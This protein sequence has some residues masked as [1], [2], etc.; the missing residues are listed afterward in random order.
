MKNDI[1]R[2]NNERAEKVKKIFTINNNNNNWMKNLLKKLICFV[3]IG[4]NEI[5][6]KKDT[7][8]YRSGNSNS[9]N[10]KR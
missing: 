9:K 2:R 3:S 10:P 6:P 4:R 1:P 8:E 5:I 7:V